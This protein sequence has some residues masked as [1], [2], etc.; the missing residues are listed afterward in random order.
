ME[1]K[2]PYQHAVKMLCE[3][4]VD[5]YERGDDPGKDSRCEKLLRSAK[6]VTEC[7]AGDEKAV[8]VEMI[9][10]A[11]KVMGL[12][13]MHLSPYPSDYIAAART[14]LAVAKLREDEER[15]EVVE[16]AKYLLESFVLDGDSL[17]ELEE[18]ILGIHKMMGR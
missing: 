12:C 2:N 6:A 15:V 18:I 3:G 13:G 10:N 8:C 5:A 17:D 4:S 11:R 16:S 9:D 14:I 1:Y 7:A